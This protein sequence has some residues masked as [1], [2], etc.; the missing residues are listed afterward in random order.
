MSWMLSTSVYSQVND[1]KEELKRAK[2]NAVE[3]AL[4]SQQKDSIIQV[5]DLYISLQES[6]IATCDSALSGYVTQNK[7]LKANLEV[8]TGKTKTNRKVAIGVG[9]LAVLEAVLIGL[10]ISK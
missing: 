9:V 6:E 5:K 2:R 1:C 8:Q 10:L 3:Q 4:I 7:Q